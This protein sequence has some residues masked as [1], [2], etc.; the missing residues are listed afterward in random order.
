MLHKK[1]DCMGSIV[2]EREREREREKEKEK[3][4]HEHQGPWC[5]DELIGGEPSVIK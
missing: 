5:Q 4:S 1:Y 3:K 2:R